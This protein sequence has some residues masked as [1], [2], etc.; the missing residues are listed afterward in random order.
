MLG[1]KVIVHF[2]LPVVSFP[3][4]HP[5]AILLQAER[6]IWYLLPIFL[7]LD[8]AI[9]CDCHVKMNC[10]F[11]RNIGKRVDYRQPHLIWLDRWLNLWMTAVV[12]ALLKRSTEYGIYPLSLFSFSVRL[13]EKDNKIKSFL[14]ATSSLKPRLVV[15]C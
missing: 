2:H 5:P 15:A 6:L 9:E 7:A 3:G 8:C 4:Q 14:Q 12:F 1:F 13:T 10:C 11:V